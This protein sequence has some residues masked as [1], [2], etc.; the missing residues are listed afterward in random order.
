M[1]DNESIQPKVKRASLLSILA[2]IMPCVLLI[3]LLIPQISSHG[4]G[5]EADLREETAAA[6]LTTSAILQGVGHF[7]AACAVAGTAPAWVAPVA[8]IAVGAVIIGV[9][10]VLWD[11]ADGSEDNC[12][13]CDG[14]GYHE[15]GENCNTCN[16]PDDDDCPNCDGSGYH[17]DGEHCDTCNPPPPPPRR[18][19]G[20]RSLQSR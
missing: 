9:C 10:I 4:P 7:G 8:A 16:P 3:T 6:L 18:T 13:D 17:S 19:Q 5:D 11:L 12:V 14:S 2:A 15:D 1:K 20:G